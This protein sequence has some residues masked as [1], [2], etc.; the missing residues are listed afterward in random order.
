MYFRVFSCICF[1][2]FSCV[3]MCFHVFTTVKEGLQLGLP[4]AKQGKEQ[5]WHAR[6][7]Q[8]GNSEASQNGALA[9]G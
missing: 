4:P 1:D 5:L 6:R 7:G 9:R 8:E 3:F 2:V